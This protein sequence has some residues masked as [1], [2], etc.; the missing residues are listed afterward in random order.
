MKSVA[1]CPV[2]GQTPFQNHRM[3]CGF[4]EPVWEALAA[5]G[6]VQAMATGAP[7]SSVSAG[8]GA[9]RSGGPTSLPPTPPPTLGL[10]RASPGLLWPLLLGAPHSTNPTSQGATV[11]PPAACLGHSEPAWWDM[12]HK[13][14]SWKR[15]SGVSPVGLGSPP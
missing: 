2:N 13:L 15:S 10:P 5:R 14:V 4:T 11:A 1:D 9:G 8:M 12:Q 3:L 6:S 7:V